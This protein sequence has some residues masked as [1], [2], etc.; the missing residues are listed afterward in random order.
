MV[1]KIA[2]H[3]PCNLR[4][5]GTKRWTSALQEDHRH[6]ASDIAIRIRGEPS[7]ARPGVRTCPGLAED[8]FLVEVQTQAARGAISDGAGHSV[9]E[10][11]NHRLDVEMAF[12]AR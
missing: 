9:R 10:F 2:V 1:V 7:E 4:R 11:G 6:D 3:T 12:D 5:F 8:R